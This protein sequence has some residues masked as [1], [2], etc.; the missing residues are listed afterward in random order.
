LARLL[1]WQGEDVVPDRT[2]THVHVPELAWGDGCVVALDPEAAR[3]Q[4]TWEVGQRTGIYQ[5]TQ[6]R[7][8]ALC[9]PADQVKQTEAVSTEAR[10]ILVVDEVLALQAVLVRLFPV[11]TDGQNLT[12]VLQNRHHVGQADTC[13]LSIY[14]VLIA[15]EVQVYVA[16]IQ[17]I[18]LVVQISEAGLTVLGFLDLGLVSTRIAQ[19]YIKVEAGVHELAQLVL[20]LAHHMSHPMAGLNVEGAVGEDDVLSR[21]E[22]RYLPAHVRVEVH[23][24][25]RRPS[26]RKAPQHLLMLWTELGHLLGQLVVHVR[27]NSE[28]S[29]LLLS[30]L[31]AN[32][33]GHDWAF[34][35]ECLHYGVALE[36]NHRLGNHWMHHATST[37]PWLSTLFVLQAEQLQ[38]VH[39]GLLPVLAGV[40][41][42]VHIRVQFTGQ[43]A[44]IAFVHVLS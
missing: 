3:L 43:S 8:G 4:T 44:Q 38:A 29:R 13:F 12:G 26:S 10:D 1:V 32:D 15:L 9:V 16:L 42:V 39:I 24:L 21:N 14:L 25:E 35:G 28:S 33:L 31:L 19:F 40:L 5:L 22:Q 41:V 7:C 2:G 36:P 27:L 34:G 11:P 37:T 23:L 30:S 18:S 20:G 6:Q 17:G